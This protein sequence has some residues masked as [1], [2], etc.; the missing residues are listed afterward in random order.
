M[1]SLA[2]ELAQN[3]LTA[4][5]SGSTVARLSCLC[6]FHNGTSHLSD[7]RLA[8]KILTLSRSLL[9]FLVTTGSELPCPRTVRPLCQGRRNVIYLVAVCAPPIMH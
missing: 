1:S 2:A 6:S 7:R 3:L 9:V 5:T 4:D 8:G